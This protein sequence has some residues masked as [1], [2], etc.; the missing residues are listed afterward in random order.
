MQEGTR[1]ADVEDGL[2]GTEGAGEDETDGE[3]SI[4]IGTPSCVKYTAGEK[5][6]YSTGSP[7][8]CSDDTEVWDAGKGGRLKTEGI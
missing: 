2:V 7:V 3:S 6:L 4:N 5:F 8:L 1:E